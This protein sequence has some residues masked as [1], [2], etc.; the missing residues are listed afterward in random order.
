[1]VGEGNVKK[2][3]KNRIGKKR[4]ERDK[5]IITQQGTALNRSD[6]GGW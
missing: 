4:V 1:M 3:G 5:F 6:I 2:K